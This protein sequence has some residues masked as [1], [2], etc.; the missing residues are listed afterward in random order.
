VLTFQIIELGYPCILLL[1]QM[2]VARKRCTID[3][4]ELERI[5]GIPVVPSIAVTGEGLDDLVSLIFKGPGRSSD[6]QVRYDS[7][8]EEMIV[9]LSNELPD[10]ATKGVRC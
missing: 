9:R 2:D 4:P 3:L 5:L 7:H 6:F 8:I 10:F 1:N